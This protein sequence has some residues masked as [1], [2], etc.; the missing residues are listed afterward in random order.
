MISRLQ[1]QHA[2]GQWLN[3][4][5]RIAKKSPLIPGRLDEYE[6]HW[7][8]RFIKDIIL[9]VEDTTLLRN[10]ESGFASSSQRLK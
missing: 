9:Y 4:Y 6:I 7:S 1:N 2:M 8:S 10:A 3:Y 5:F